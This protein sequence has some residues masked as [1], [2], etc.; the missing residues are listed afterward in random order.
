MQITTLFVDLDGTLYPATNG[1]WDDIADRMNQYIHTNF[2]IPLEDVPA[3]RYDYYTQY[4]TTLRGL[5]LNYEIDS[6]DY[7]DYVHDIPLDKYIEP[8]PVLRAMLE[9]LP[10][11]KWILTNADRNHAFRVLAKLGIDDLFSGTVDVWATDF[12]PKPDPYVFKC[13]LKIAGNPPPESCLFV[14]DIPKNLAPAKKLGFT[15]VL[16]GDK[17]SENSHDFHIEEIHDLA[18]IPALQK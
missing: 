15:T 14:D 12:H 10:Q 7:L 8:D 6:E 13:A 9:Q 11:P 3:F 18:Q 17:E 1:M 4:G 5:Q 16:V 2:G